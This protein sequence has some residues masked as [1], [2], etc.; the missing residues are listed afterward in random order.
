MRINRKWI[1]LG[2][3]VS[4]LLMATQFLSG[5]HIATQLQNIKYEKDFSKVRIG[6]TYQDMIDGMGIPEYNGGGTSCYT[7][8]YSDTCFHR[9]ETNYRR[10]TIVTEDNII[11]GWNER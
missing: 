10:I 8:E 2:L 1:S 9:Y 4:I 6:N 3:T 11:T 5:C 7:S